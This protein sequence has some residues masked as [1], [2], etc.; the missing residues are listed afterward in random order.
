MDQP[1]KSEYPRDFAMAARINAKIPFSSSGDMM[2]N[3]K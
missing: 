2:P 3:V 1:K